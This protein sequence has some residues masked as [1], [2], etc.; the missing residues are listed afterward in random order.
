[1]NIWKAQTLLVGSCLFLVSCA[2]KTTGP[3]DVPEQESKPIVK[4]P[5]ARP[6]AEATASYYGDE[7][8]GAKTASGE[9][10]NPNDFTAAHKKYPFGTQ[11]KVT[12]PK[13]GKS[14]TVR[15]ND[16]G[17]FV[18]GRDIDLSKAAAKELGITDH[19]VADVKVELLQPK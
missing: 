13:N 9:R 18:K 3:V 12:N 8:K 2:A 6:I 15:V 19:G 16:R 10:F 1:M 17:P 11:L 14:V 7:F 5:S 4:E